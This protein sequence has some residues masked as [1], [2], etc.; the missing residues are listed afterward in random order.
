MKCYF[1]LLLIFIPGKLLSQGFVPDAGVKTPLHE[2]NI[3][4]VRFTAKEV[5]LTGSS[6]QDFLQ[7][8]ELTNTSD[9]FFT[10]FMAHSL[11]NYLHQ[12][13][14][15][16]PADSLHKIGG[17]QFSIFVD[18]R[19]IYASRIQGA[20]LPAV[21]DSETVIRKPLIDNAAENGWWTQ[22]FWR[23]FLYNGGDSALTDGRHLLRLE[24]RPYLRDTIG[25]IIA[26]GNLDLVV[27]R[28]PAVDVRKVQLNVIQP[29][30]ELKASKEHFNQ[31]RIKELKAR[32][33]QGE[34]RKIN[35]VIV[36]KNGKI[37]VEEYFNG[38]TRDSLHDPRSVGKSFTSTL[39]GIAIKEGYFNDEYLPLSNFY[40][41]QAFSNYSAEK[42]RITLQD[43]LTM[44]AAFDGD[45]NDD[46]SPGNEENMYPTENWI[47]F[48]LDLP[49][50]KSGK[51]DWHY[52]TA[53][54]VV[55]GD[56]LNKTIPGG[57]EKYA[58]D[59]LFGPLDIRYQW[60]YTPQHVP[61]TAGG[62]RL[63]A[64][65]FAR[66]G[67]LYKNRGRWKGRQLIPGEWVEKTFT[68]YQQIP[69]K[70]GE[71]YG[72]LF[73]N[74]QYQVGGKTYETWYCTGNGG[75][76]IFVFKDQPLVI[77][78]TASAYGQPYAHSQVD[79]MMKD[80]ILPAVLK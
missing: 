62:I 40:S 52:F 21:R 59:K 6:A 77:V 70:P 64:L 42:A 27:N 76:K 31:D 48:A 55:L 32:I 72:Y 9:L 60:Q 30:K 35:S 51:Y 47:K 80:Y 67:L 1:I 41:L 26:A 71:Y 12:L 49:L 5:P 18:K 29:F 2:S 74:K 61:N 65:D 46:N 66:Y 28:H 4:A 57:L 8:Y 10:A 36:I 11:T 14:P 20:P 38:D 58:A 23:R 34:F 13:G 50:I 69:G 22:F 24:I 16:L 73:W 63:S 25:A 45:D 17:Y 44:H 39:L 56:I 19:L 78:V 37:L 68:K 75:N 15:E 33:K 43:L 3:G 79:R 54:V 7:T 53:G